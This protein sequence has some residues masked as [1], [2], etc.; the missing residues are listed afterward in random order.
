MTVEAGA[1][2]PSV[3][4]FPAPYAWKRAVS[5]LT[6]CGVALGRDRDMLALDCLAAQEHGWKS[7]GRCQPRLTHA[8]R[9][10]TVHS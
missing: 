4:K 8:L 5:L 9:L 10:S 6:I 1:G 3:W 7:V 2:A